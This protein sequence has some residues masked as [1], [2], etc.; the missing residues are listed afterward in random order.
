[1]PNFFKNEVVKICVYVLSAILFGALLAPWL[2]NFVKSLSIGGSL[3]AEIERA[4]FGRVFNRAM[5]I[6][7]LLGIWP[8]IKWIGVRPKE[9]LQL[10]ANPKKWSQLGLSFALGAGGLLLLG[11]VLTMTGVFAVGNAHQSKTIQAR[12]GKT[13][14]LSVESLAIK[15]PDQLNSSQRFRVVDPDGGE[16]QL[17]ETGAAITSFTLQQL[18]DDHVQLTN[19]SND[20]KP[21]V[22]IVYLRDFNLW[23]LIFG[24]LVAGICVAL[25]EEFFFRGCLLGLAVRNM[26]QLT[27][28]LSVSA[29]FSIVHFLKPPEHTLNYPEV[30]EWWAGFWYAGQIF[31]QFGN[32][33][34][35]LAEFTLLFVVGWVLGYARLKTNSLWLSIGLHAGWVFGIKVFSGITRRAIPP[36]ETA[37]WVG[38]SLRSG[39]ASM[40]VLALSGIIVWWW[41]KRVSDKN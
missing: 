28:L 38:P 35:I 27:A 16:F 3:G 8:L 2:Y 1:M 30:I 22:T 26:R 25:L 15:N 18:R 21:K 29:F 33:V 41:L 37:I 17:A 9:F 39:M 6:G 10:Q 5:M 14:T 34:F 7:A 23:T 24:A 4:S 19:V 40:L 13:A 12:P 36:E 20:E 31:A 32:P 11:W